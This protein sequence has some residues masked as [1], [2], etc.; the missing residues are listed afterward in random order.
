[1]KQGPKGFVSVDDLNTAFIKPNTSGLRSSIALNMMDIARPPNV[2]KSQVLISHAWREDVLQV[3][4]L[5]ENATGTVLKSGGRFGDST[6]VW[7]CAFA[8][9]QSG[10]DAEGPTE[11]AQLG[12][13]PFKQITQAVKDMFVLQTSICDPYSKLWCVSELSIALA[14]E[15]DNMQ[16]HP[17]FSTEWAQKYVRYV[18]V[19]IESVWDLIDG[20]R[21]YI[22][23][24]KEAVGEP[25]VL[26]RKSTYRDI[27][28]PNNRGNEGAKTYYLMNENETVKETDDGPENPVLR[29][30]VMR[31]LT[32]FGVHEGTREADGNEFRRLNDLPG[33]W[34][35][36]QNIIVRFQHNAARDFYDE[37]FPALSP[38][39]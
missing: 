21:V 13:K 24:T 32:E 30:S 10:T 7:F 14:L 37:M 18:N 22:Q 3:I 29:F 8:L 34:M 33:E 31:G 15:P 23:R 9:Y 16:I 35:R 20:K 27:Q 25:T 11:A 38:P 5:L 39:S 2:S 12:I 28:D 6:I 36:M 1:M 26:T 4:D 17:L 19:D